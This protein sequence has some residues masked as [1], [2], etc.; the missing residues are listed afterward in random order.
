VPAAAAAAAAAASITTAPTLLQNN[1]SLH[2]LKGAAPQSITPQR[3]KSPLRC[4]SHIHRHQSP[5]HRPARRSLSPIRQTGSVHI[6][7]RSSVTQMASPRTDEDWHAAHVT[8]SS[9]MPDGSCEPSNSGSFEPHSVSALSTAGTFPR[10]D[11]DGKQTDSV[12][13]PAGST[14]V[15]T[16]TF[17][18]QECGQ[19]PASA[20]WTPRTPSGPG[21]PGPTLSGVN[22]PCMSPTVPSGTRSP[23]IGARTP[24]IGSP[25]PSNVIPEG[26]SIA[27]DTPLDVTMQALSSPGQELQRSPLVPS[28]GHSVRT[29]PPMVESRGCSVHTTPSLV[30]SA[31]GLN[32]NAP[33]T[34]S[35]CRMSRALLAG[36][37]GCSAAVVAAV[38]GGMRRQGSLS[39][40]SL[41]M[42]YFSD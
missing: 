42:V 1:A 41:P 5:C 38:A 4:S 7:V 22:T 39:E 20:G 2:R 9:L 34:G 8:T 40:P 28:R 15:P 17:F 6:S 19:A 30:S 37:A 18:E 13:S 23:P 10:S 24:P 36:R 27:P 21:T 29:A 11:V 14:V 3:P 25:H 16:T 33:S 31:R 32:I 12:S 26:A 35:G